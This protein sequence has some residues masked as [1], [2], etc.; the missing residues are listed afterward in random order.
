MNIS[1]YLQETEKII[2]N[3]FA[4]WFYCLSFFFPPFPPPQ[5]SLKVTDTW[6][7]WAHLAQFRQGDCRAQG[8]PCVTD[9][10]STTECS[11]AVLQW[12]STPALMCI[13]KSHSHCGEETC[14]ESGEENGGEI[15][16]LHFG[17][18]CTLRDSSC[19]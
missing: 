7:Y 4:T 16:P 3:K 11:P 19:G 13:R 18:G 5:K 9:V 8:L 12:A 14:K 1:D 10:S 6:V 15:S 2:N 17:K